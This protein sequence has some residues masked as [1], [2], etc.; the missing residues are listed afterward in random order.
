MPRQGP[1]ATGAYVPNVA[2]SIGWTPLDAVPANMVGET[3]SGQPG[4]SA[5]V[6]QERAEMEGTVRA[7]HTCNR[8]RKVKKKH[9][10]PIINLGNI[11]FD[12]K[13]YGIYSLFSW[14][15]VS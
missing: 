15:Y 2:I 14:T 7:S 1:S 10:I 13:V 9:V 8:H 12:F 11:V 3:V 4:K 6:A 5:P